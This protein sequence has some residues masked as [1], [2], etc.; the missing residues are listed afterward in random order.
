MSAVRILSGAAIVLPLAGCASQSPND[1]QFAKAQTACARLGVVPGS[2]VYGDCL[3]D[4]DSTL[5]ALN[6][7]DP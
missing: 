1:V 7:A 6:F 4:L 3:A 5:L 2:S